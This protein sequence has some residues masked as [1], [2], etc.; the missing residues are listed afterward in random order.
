MKKLINKT[1]SVAIALSLSIVGIGY[2]F[3]NHNK[4]SV[5]IKPQDDFYQFV[6]EKW[7]DQTTIPK[8]KSMYSTFH[9]IKDKN[10]KRL[11]QLIQTLIQQ[12]VSER[13]AETNNIVNIYNSFLSENTLEK[14]GLKP[15]SNELTQI[16]HI[17]TPEDV[18]KVMAQLQQI[19]VSLPF[20]LGVSQDMKHADQYI[21]GIYQSG[22]GLPDKEYYLSS[23]PNFLNIQ[24]NYIQHMTQ[25]FSLAHF[26]NPEQRAQQVFELEKKLAASH[27]SRVDS[28][29]YDKI[30]NKFD[31]NE[32]NKVT[33]HIKWANYLSDIHIPVKDLESLVIYQPSAL[34]AFDK[35]LYSVP[36]EDWKNYLR[37]HL[38]STYAPYLNKAFVDQDFEFY[39][40]QLGGLLE[41]TPRKKRGIELVN[42]TLGEAL[43]Q[44]YVK[45][46]F[47]AESQQEMERLVGNLK[48]AFKLS[49]DHNTWMTPKTK[50]AALLKLSKITYKIGHPTEWKSYEGL[51]F[52]QQSLIQNIMDSSQY[53]FN[54]NMG[55][56]NQPV[57]RTEWHILP[58]T[59]NAY[60]SP[61]LNEIVFP[62]AILQAPFF[63]RKASHAQNYGAIGAI[64]GHEISHAFDDQG[65]KFDGDGNLNDWWTPTDL[66]NFTEY[67]KNLVKQY[68]QYEPLSGIHLNGELTLGENIADISGLSIAYR[69]FHLAE[70]SSPKQNQEF[71]VS[72]AQ[73]WK[74]KIR[75]EELQ[76]RLLTDPH[77]PG[78]YRA[79]GTVKNIDA[80]YQAFNVQP[81]DKMYLPPSQRIN[82]WSFGSA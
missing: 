57:D 16:V 27:W 55:K 22:L 67:T 73:S 14:L 61:N 81:D 74:N 35:L 66:Q 60:Y 80:F 11:A 41:N 58:Q 68:G 75:P 56:L 47:S 76:Q 28:R 1:Y 8:D 52:S 26:K 2:Y 21:L 69:A 3:M 31:I 38:L 29:N 54:R 46:Y 4:P 24:K 36:L 48:Q 23:T 9:I 37:W 79:N 45:K 65:R 32:L 43:G 13:N 49:L 5:D 72:W 71:F 34:T 20:G 82:L 64:I 17:Q 63:D 10:E 62:A 77:S 30:Y 59:V 6:N 15:L 40:K 53:E 19:G 70:K 51:H 25:M 42:Q 78:I 18:L 44:A 7:L 12:P 50:E 33:P 39:G